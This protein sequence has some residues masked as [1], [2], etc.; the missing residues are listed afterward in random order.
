MK[1]RINV[2]TLGVHD[3]E[4]RPAFYRD[5]LALPT[6]E[7][8]VTEFDD[9]HLFNMNEVCGLSKER[10]LSRI[11]YFGQA[12]RGRLTSRR[13]RTSNCHRSGAQPLWAR[14]TPDI[15]RILTN[16]FGAI[17]WNQR[18]TP[19]SRKTQHE[20]MRLAGCG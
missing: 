16:A 13:S 18:G 17:A 12:R 4:R 15:F 5:G 3:L 7:I 9:G 2:S 14:G 19:G 10:C 1:P 11:R 6:Q 20:T 8:I